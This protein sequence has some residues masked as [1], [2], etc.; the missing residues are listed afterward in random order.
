MQWLAAVSVRRPVFASV[1]IL[2][3]VV[4]GAFSYVTLG[5]D[6]FPDVDFPVVSVTTRQ[7]GATPED[8]ETEITDKLER[9]VNTIAGIQELR[10][11]S[12]EG[13][14]QVFVEFQLDKDVD[15]AAQEVRDK[16]NQVLAELPRDVD[17]PV[18]D[19]VDTSAAPVIY[20]ALA[21]NR[22]IREITELADKTLRRELDAFDPT[23][24]R[25]PSVVVGTKADL[26]DAPDLAAATLGPEALV[27]SA[28][29]GEGLDRL[30]GRLS[31]LARQP[32]AAAAER[33]RSSALSSVA[34]V[35]GRS[36]P[37]STSGC[38]TSPVSGR[39]RSCCS[40][41]GSAR[42]TSATGTAWTRALPAGSRSSRRKLRV[43]HAPRFRRETS[44]R[45]QTPS[46]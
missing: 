34:S 17:P 16:V 18:V 15:V 27:V 24:L 32:G 31:D 20:L 42:T 43:A 1:L 5:V 39:A 2:S 45:R 22:P 21:A 4:V 26:V 38:S 23:L 46:P 14:S 25:R 6:R 29:T 37:N 40:A 7:P 19:K 10:S 13:V 35:A 44:P 11:V 9:A 36:P 30:R 41:G 12:T 28:V 8:I 33:G 3:L